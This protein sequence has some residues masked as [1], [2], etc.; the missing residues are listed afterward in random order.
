[1]DAISTIQ[2]TLEMIDK[3]ILYIEKQNLAYVTEA[4]TLATID[5]RK[6]LN[7]IRKKKL[8]EKE[9]ETLNGQQ[10]NLET[11][12]H[13]LKNIQMNVMVVDAMVTASKTL[14]EQN[15]ML[16]IDNIDDLQDQIAESLQ[17]AQE[18]SKSLSQ[19]IIASDIDI[20]DLED[21][22]KA[23]EEETLPEE[24]DKELLELPDAPE[25]SSVNKPLSE[26]ERELTQLVAEF[27]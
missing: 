2:D 21:E 5:K 8:N 13:S 16:N 18:I 4:K 7:L 6:A 19:P 23:L 1:M 12:L 14:K 3:K 22:L 27:A 9:L 26:E 24:L 25:T 20:D 10:I 17:D 15:K 11:P